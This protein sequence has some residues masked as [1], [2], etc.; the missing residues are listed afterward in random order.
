[1]DTQTNGEGG[2]KPAVVRLAAVGDL[3]CKRTP[4]EALHNLMAALRD[5]HL[6]VLCLCGDLTDHGLPEE[7]HALVRELRG[8]IQRCPVLAVFGNHDHHAARQEEVSAILTDAGVSVLDGDVAEVGGVGFIGIKGFVGGF[9]ERALQPWGEETIKRFV[10]ETVDEVL[11]LEAG[12]A[13][14]RTPQRV[15]LLHYAPIRATVEGESPEIFPFLGSS[16]LEEPINLYPVSA[17]F[18]CHAHQGQ[19]EGRTSR[20]VPVYNVSMP[21]LQHAYPDR[22]P[23]RLLDIAVTA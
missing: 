4:G 12:L 14:L 10:H 3:H 17:V 18:H 23:Y 5:D 2:R 6:D 16:R 9:G 1:M 15:V 21:L 11:K 19:P 22:P 8:V 7:A 20:D 13:K